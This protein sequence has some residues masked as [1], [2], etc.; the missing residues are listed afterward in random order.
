MLSFVQHLINHT[1]TYESPK[2]FWLWS[3]YAAIAGVLRD[4]VWLA[5]GD[6]RL[7]PNIYV[8]FLAQSAAR[9]GAPVQLAER[10]VHDVNTVKI[11][12]GRSSIQAILREI[13][14]TETDENGKIKKGGSAIFFAPEF[15]AGLVQDDQSVQ[16]LTDIYDFKITPHVTNLIGAG[17][18]KIDKLVFSL[19]GA[20]NQELLKDMYTSKAIEGGLLGRT[21]LIVPDEFRQSN[22]FP[23]GDNESY[24]KLLDKLRE[25]ANL[26][27]PVTWSPEAREFYRLW[28]EGPDGF[29]NQSKERPDRGGVLGRIPTSAKKLALILAANDLSTEIQLRHVET[30]V[31]QCL[32]LIKNYSV[33]QISQGKSTIAGTGSIILESLYRANG[34]FL[35]R[36]EIIRNNWMHFDPELF[37]KTIAAFESVK[38]VTAYIDSGKAYYKLGPKGIEIMQGVI[39]GQDK[40]LKKGN[41]Q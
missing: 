12:S 23:E 9:K 30:A 5:H 21:F 10:L 31:D 25:I 37:D 27:G 41:G 15:S 36:D 18:V 40:S 34:Y 14:H 26:E 20:S 3:A 17:K 2:S 6:S 16:I 33:F 11:I 39:P 8:L 7:Y 24:M 38:I 13:A 32:S 4:N 29:R 1:K 35:S 19:F 22:A 28:Y